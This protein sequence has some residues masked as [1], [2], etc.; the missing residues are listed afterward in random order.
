MYG[1]NVIASLANFAFTK[2][3]A[4]SS[5]ELAFFFTSI[6][7][8]FLEQTDIIK[9]FVEVHN[10]Y[11]LILCLQQCASQN[12]GLQ[13]HTLIMQALTSLNL[14]IP[15]IFGQEIGKDIILQAYKDHLSLDEFKEFVKDQEDYNLFELSLN[16]AIKYEDASQLTIVPVQ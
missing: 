14:K 4:G 11:A 7:R 5:T 1:Y 10:Y 3:K 16:A 15:L 9:E 2:P 6:L 12:K 13:V 8:S